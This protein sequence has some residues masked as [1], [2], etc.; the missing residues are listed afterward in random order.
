VEATQ[1]N[2][3]PDKPEASNKSAEAPVDPSAEGSSANTSLREISSDD[4]N[5]RPAATDPGDQ[6]AMEIHHPDKPIHSKKDF[7]VHMLTVVLGILIALGLEATV[8][9][10]HHRALVREARENLATEIAHNRK[11]LDDGMPEIAKRKENLQN[12]QRY[13]AAAKK[14]KVIHGAFSFGWAG[15]DLYAT[16]WKTAET[17]GATAYMS[18][19]ELKEYTE[20]YDLQQI[21]QTFQ[22][23]AYHNMVD[24]AELPTVMEEDPKKVPQEVLREME[25]LVS[26]G[27]IVNNIVTNAA[28]QLKQQYEGFQ[29]RK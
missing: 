25:T 22:S 18:Y 2:P 13:L 19:D 9:W 3:S 23:D 21:F 15:F 1:E 26:K 11:T 28:T 29:N 8:Q 7:L 4:A 24:M 20:L 27:I 6:D 10:G 5:R 16:A 14:G 17:S 12:I